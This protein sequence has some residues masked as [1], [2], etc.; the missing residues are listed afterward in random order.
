MA[1]QINVV[2]II[3]QDSHGTIKMANGAVA[4][5]KHPSILTSMNVVPT[6]LSKESANVVQ[7]HHHHHQINVHV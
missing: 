3:H 6:D 5:V 2:E 4:V 1:N 7:L